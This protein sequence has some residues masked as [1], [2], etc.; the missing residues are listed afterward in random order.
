MAKKQTWTVV[1]E[2]F[3]SRNIHRVQMMG[4]LMDEVAEENG[5]KYPEWDD[6]VPKWVLEVMERA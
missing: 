2:R 3:F 6:E 5:G 1:Y 4:R